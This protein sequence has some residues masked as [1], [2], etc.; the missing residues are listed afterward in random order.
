MM[1]KANAEYELAMRQ[2]RRYQES[3]K[4]ADLKPTLAD[5]EFMRQRG[6]NI[7]GHAQIS[8]HD[9]LDIDEGD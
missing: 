4:I 6:F 5:V 1:T 2:G 7:W 9:L 8:V 3:G